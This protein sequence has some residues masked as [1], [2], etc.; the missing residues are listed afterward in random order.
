MKLSICYSVHWY[1]IRARCGLL[2]D[3]MFHSFDIKNSSITNQPQCSPGFN[4]FNGF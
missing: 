2:F 3:A 4:Q 1:V